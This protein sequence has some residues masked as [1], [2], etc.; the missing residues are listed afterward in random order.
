MCAH[1][2]IH[3]GKRGGE[4]SR[5]RRMCM[6]PSLTRNR[7][8]SLSLTQKPPA[9]KRWRWASAL[10]GAGQSWYHDGG[11][12]GSVTQISSAPGLPPSGE[13]AFAHLLPLSCMCMNLFIEVL[14]MCVDGE[15][16]KNH[17]C[18]FG[19]EGQG[20]SF[21]EQDAEFWYTQK[22]D[23]SVQTRLIQGYSS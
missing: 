18:G 1:T 17:G 13:D 7:S 11:M 5:P 21:C 9:A 20:R 2:H 12:L 23:L 6:F 3:F 16:V 19:I 14:D 22:T 8:I 10:I 15:E 4:K